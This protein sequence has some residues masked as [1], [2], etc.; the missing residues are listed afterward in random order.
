WRPEAAFSSS[1]RTGA[2]PP[3][4]G[5]AAP[6]ATREP[7]R[8]RHSLGGRRAGLNQATGEY[9]A[10]PA[11]KS[12]RGAWV[13]THALRPSVGS[14]E[15]STVLVARVGAVGPTRASLDS[16]AHNPDVG[17]SDPGDRLFRAPSRSRESEDE[18]RRLTVSGSSGMRFL[19]RQ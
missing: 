10:A 7:A 1:C 19:R 11:R 9:I 8:R 16:A 3:G 12:L 4:R 14:T 6:Y 13:G 17:A 18:N 5:L 2:C 15:A